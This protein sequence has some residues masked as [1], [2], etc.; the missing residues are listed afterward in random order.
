LRTKRRLLRLALQENGWLWTSYFFLYYFFGSD[1][2]YQKMQSR[3]LAA[4]SPGLNSPAFNQVLWSHWDWSEGGEEWTPSP[5]WK[6]SLCRQVM[7]RLPRGGVLLEIGPG[8]GRWT[9][10][11]VESAD[12]WVAVDLEGP[13]LELLRAKYAGHPKVQVLAGNGADLFFQPA[14]SVD[15][16]WSF[17]VFVHLNTPAVQIYLKEIHRVLKPGGRALLHLGLEAGRQG[18]WRSDLTEESF[19]HAL[20]SAGLALTERFSSWEDG[21]QSFQVGWPGDILAILVKE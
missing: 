10:S 11:L 12:Q 5:A 16:V 21:G 4:G 6:E 7:K 19:Q 14:E 13:A 1:W 2:A 8:A 17:D 3:R 9:A 18:G 15:G 20:G